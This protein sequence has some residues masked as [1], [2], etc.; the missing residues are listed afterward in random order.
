MHCEETTLTSN[1]NTCV[2]CFRVFRFC[3]I[4][5]LYDYLLLCLA[6]LYVSSVRHVLLFLSGVHFVKFLRRILI[7]PDYLGI[8]GATCICLTICPELPKIAAEYIR[9]SPKHVDYM[10]KV[11]AV[12]LNKWGRAFKKV[13]KGDF[14]KLFM[15]PPLMRRLK[16]KRKGRRIIQFRGPLKIMDAFW[17]Y[18]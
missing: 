7:L 9:M 15:F 3:V 5:T 6:Y 10:Q 1:T 12:I 11:G 13:D 14:V 2:S 16:L 17:E 8:G 18:I 4:F